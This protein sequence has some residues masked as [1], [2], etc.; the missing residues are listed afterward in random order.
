MNDKD[1]D[2]AAKADQAVAGKAY[3]ETAPFSPLR[4]RL[5]SDMENLAGQH[6]RSFRA[7]QILEAHPEFEE[8]IELLGLI[9]VD[10]RFRP[11]Q[12]QRALVT[13]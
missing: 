13:E 11:V 2:Q 9:R 12:A 7:N 1:F 8:L 10:I 6:Q 5:Q 4:A 3:A